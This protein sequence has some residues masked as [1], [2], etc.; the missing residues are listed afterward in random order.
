MGCVGSGEK[1]KTLERTD[2]NTVAV[3]ILGVSGCGKS[4]FVKQ[5]KIIS[6]SGFQDFELDNYKKIIIKNLGSGL[7]ELMNIFSES[8]GSLEDENKEAGELFKQNPS[9][10][11]SEGDTIDKAKKLWEDKN[12]IK[13]WDKAKYSVHYTHLDYYMEN[14]DRVTAADYSP[15][16]DDIVRSRQYTIGASTTYI[17]YEKFWWRFIDVG[18]QTPERNKWS[19][20]VQDTP[21]NALV[22]FIALD[23]YHEESPEQ[24]GKTKMEVSKDVWD[25]VIHSGLFKRETTIL[26]LNKMDLFSKQI[27]N[28]KQFKLF[29]KQFP[30]Y[31]SN[32]KNDVDAAAE[33]IKNQ[34][35]EI[36][37]DEAE[38]EKKKYIIIIP[39]LL[40]LKICRKYGI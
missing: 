28:K 12:I 33:Y 10:D 2:K 24:K 1:G 36:A 15:T 18:G 13:I 32:D 7:H 34:F 16:F 20:I 19:A 22:Y 5:M 39:V 4:T 27:K 17:S 29:K 35:I 31:E 9:V 23:D 40:I 3:L 21:I 11:W 37:K 14:I 8:E 38:S 25:E 30:E 26:F 6:N